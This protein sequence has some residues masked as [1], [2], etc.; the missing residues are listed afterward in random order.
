LSSAWLARSFSDG[1]CAPPIA[2]SAAQRSRFCGT[3]G[4][5]EI[6][7]ISREVQD[8]CLSDTGAS[9]P[10]QGTELRMVTHG[11]RFQRAGVERHNFWMQEGAAHR[12]RTGDHRGGYKAGTGWWVRWIDDRGVRA[13]A[14]LKQVLGFQA[15]PT[16][17]ERRA[18]K[19]SYS[20]PTATC[21]TTA[22]QRLACHLL[23][24]RRARLVLL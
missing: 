9:T 24:E 14:D 7:E 1:G 17:E 18:P 4:R 10:S 12:K 8:D 23:A 15:P 20:G 22:R 5:R 16:G 6:L 3:V 2:P 13:Q 19:M 21:C 11:A